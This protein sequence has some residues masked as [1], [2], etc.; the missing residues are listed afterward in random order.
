MKR[1]GVTTWAWVPV[2]LFA[3]LALQ[4][5]RADGDVMQLH[6][7]QGPFLV[8]VFVAPEAAHGGLIDVSVLVQ[9]RTDAEVILD[10]DVGLMVDPPKALLTAS[11]PFCGFPSTGAGLQLPDAE[12]PQA[13]V[14]ATREQASNKL[15]Y[16]AGLNLKATGDWPL[17]VYVSRGSDRARFDCLLPIT[18]TSTTLSGLWPYLAFP[19]VV[20]LAFGMNQRLRRN[21]LENGFESQSPTVCRA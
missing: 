7:A 6:E 15:L 19:P 2:A 9:Q 17:H 18:R 21:A 4:H 20:I 11:E 14:Q 3:T 5:A 13:T 10:A 16:A 1:S 12:Q 8:T